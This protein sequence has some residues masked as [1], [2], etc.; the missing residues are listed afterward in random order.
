MVWV[1]DEDRWYKEK[2]SWTSAKK[3]KNEK[4]FNINKIVR[5]RSDHDKEFENVIFDKFC[6]MHGI[7][8]KIFAPKTP[9]QNSMVERKIGPSK[10]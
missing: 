10:K 5:I 8:H 4:D 3:L 2:L 6:A 1:G 7:A 9:Q